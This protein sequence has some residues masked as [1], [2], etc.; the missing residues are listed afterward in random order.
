MSFEIHVEEDYNLVELSGESD[1][2]EMDEINAALSDGLLETPYVI[3]QQLGESNIEE[4]FISRLVDLRDAVMAANGLLLLVGFS[5]P[6]CDVL[7]ENDSTTIPSFDEA[8]DY[9][10]MDRLEKEMDAEDGLN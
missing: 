5:R 8:V 10:F 6:D 2:M 7:D 3:I 4:E 9:I 1:V